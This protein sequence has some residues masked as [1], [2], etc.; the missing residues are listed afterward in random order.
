MPFIKPIVPIDSKSSWSIFVFEYFLQTCA[1]NL[2]FLSTSKSLASLFPS[3]YF[4]SAIFS[5]SAVN[6]SGNIVVPVM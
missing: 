1:T 5:S 4:S 2:K 3:L 6:G